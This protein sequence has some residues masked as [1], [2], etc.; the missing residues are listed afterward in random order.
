M[1]VSVVAV[2]VVVIGVVVVVDAAVVA[3]RIGRWACY[4]LLER[5]YE[6][7]GDVWLPRYECYAIPGGKAVGL[8]K[9][10]KQLPLVLKPEQS[11]TVQ[12]FKYCYEAV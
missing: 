4:K 9:S 7:R 8:Y 2:I 6:K 12:N 3:I 5:C 10:F 11:A 1:F